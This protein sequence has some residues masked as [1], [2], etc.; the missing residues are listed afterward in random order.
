MHMLMM[1]YKKP[2]NEGVYIIH[3]PREA[4]LGPIKTIFEFDTDS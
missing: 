3:I 4:H 2:E 1:S